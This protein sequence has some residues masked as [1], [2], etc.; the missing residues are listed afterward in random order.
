MRTRLETDDDEALV[1]PPDVLEE[2]ERALDD[3]AERWTRAIV[4]TLTNAQQ[5]ADTGQPRV[6]ARAIILHTA[7]QSVWLVD[8]G[9]E[10]TPSGRLCMFPGGGQQLGESLAETAI[11]ETREETGLDIAVDG[12]LLDVGDAHAARRYFLTHVV[13]GQIRTRDADGGQRV[14]VRLVPVAEALM[15]LSSHY[16]QTALRQALSMSDARHD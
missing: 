4:D 13:G 12:W 10:S 8:T 16:D 15:Q 5:E 11:R 1:I 6:M 3:E 14:Q 9:G 7:A 2:I